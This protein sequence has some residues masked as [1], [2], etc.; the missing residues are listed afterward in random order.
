MIKLTANRGD[1]LIELAAEQAPLTCANL[2]QYVRDGHNDF[3]RTE[4]LP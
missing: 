2:E 3:E 4:I 1:I